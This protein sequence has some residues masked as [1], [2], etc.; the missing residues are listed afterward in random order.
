MATYAVMERIAWRDYPCET[1][2]VSSIRLFI[3]GSLAERGAMHGHAL[4][5]LAEEEHID[6]WADFTSGAV[7]GAIK[8]LDTEGLISSER[9]ERDGNYPERS[10]YGVTDAGREA[11]DA[12][13]LEG[14]TNI[15]MRPD[16]VDLALA[17]LDPDRLDD[18]G[19]VLA[20]R[21]SELRLRLDDG[22]THLASIAHHLTVAE[23][24]VMR[25]QLAR[26]RAEID[27]HD[28]FISALPEIIHDERRRKCDLT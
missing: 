13:R 22:A 23:R 20:T 3:L 10:V 1:S 4:M 6:N 24:Y 21:V 27:W 17:R 9:V 15:V 26:L 11:L 12:L 16:P 25:H 28:E 7:Y 5:L 19:L 8:R 14:L 2:L 18:L